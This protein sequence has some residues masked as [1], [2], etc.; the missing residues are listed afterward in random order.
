MD[1]R[2]EV[3]EGR[4]KGDTERDEKGRERINEI[5]IQTKPIQPK[6]TLLKGKYLSYICISRPVY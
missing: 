5:R 4:R 1:E 2:K 6:I 3:K